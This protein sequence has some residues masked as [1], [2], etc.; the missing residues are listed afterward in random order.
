MFV[1]MDVLRSNFANVGLR[2]RKG[3]KREFGVEKEEVLHTAQALRADLMP[4][5]S[6]G[7]RSAW[8]DRDEEGE[9]YKQMTKEGK[10]A[11]T[12]R[13]TTLG[14]MAEAVEAAFAAKE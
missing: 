14:E 2:C 13:F 7:M 8:I 10:I 3:V 4:A 11:V 1:G 5:K 6:M 9:K 12:W